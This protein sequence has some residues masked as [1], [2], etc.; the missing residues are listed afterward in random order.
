MKLALLCLFSSLLLAGCS[1]RQVYD[2]IQHNQ[3][4]ECQKRPPAQYDECMAEVDT[5]YDDY[6]RERESLE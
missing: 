6:Q 1:Q 4:L 5:S 3:Q 2:S